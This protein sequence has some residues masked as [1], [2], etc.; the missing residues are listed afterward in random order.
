MPLLVLRQ[1][2]LGTLVLFV[3]HAQH[4]IVHNLGRGLRVRLLELI[5]RIVVIADVG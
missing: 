4:L 2:S 1:D 5:F 3:D